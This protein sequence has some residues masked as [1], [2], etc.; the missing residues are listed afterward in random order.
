MALVCGWLSCSPLWSLQTSVYLS[1]EVQ[2]AA[3]F[4]RNS[5]IYAQFGRLVIR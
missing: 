3:V 5:H 4:L 1:I 2:V